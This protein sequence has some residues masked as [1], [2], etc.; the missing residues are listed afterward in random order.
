MRSNQT[1]VSLVNVI[2]LNE[3]DRRVD[4]RTLH[5]WLR[6][7]TRFN[8]WIKRRIEDCRLVTDQDYW[9]LKN[10]YND[11]SE[12]WLSFRAAQ[13]I[14][15]IERTDKGN[16]ARRYFVDVEERFFRIRD[17]LIPKL[18]EENRQLKELT[19]RL[20]RTKRILRNG[21]TMVCRTILEKQ[22]DI[23]GSWFIVTKRE[24][25][26]FDSLMPEERREERIRHRNKTIKG[27][28]AGQEKDLN[29]VIFLNEK[30]TQNLLK[31]KKLEET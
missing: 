1:E 21:V 27:I 30:S 31:A 10:E 5:R 9:L 4:A 2:K 29:S 23:F 14:S 15:M 28:T 3:S 19:E 11:Y 12:L 26:P 6:S 16:E 25:A 18:Q 20:C 7:S 24:M 8:D 17:E 22:K 13:M